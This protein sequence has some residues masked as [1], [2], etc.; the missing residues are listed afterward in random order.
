MIRRRSSGRGVKSDGEFFFNSAC[1]EKTVLLYIANIIESWLTERYPDIIFG[2]VS[3]FLGLRII[4][5]M[6]REEYPEAPLCESSDD[7]NIWIKHDA[8]KNYFGKIM[9]GKVLSEIENKLN[10]IISQ[11]DEELSIRLN[12]IKRA[13]SLNDEEVDILA[14]FYFVW[15]YQ[16]LANRLT[17]NGVIDFSN[18][19]TFKNMGHIILGHDK[20]K[21]LSNFSKRLLFT[22]SLL[23]KNHDCIEATTWA[24]N[25]LSGFLTTDISN[26]F[27]NTT[28]DTCLDLRDFDVSEEELLILN[29]L[30]EG[31][32]GCNIL[33]YGPPG[34]GK[35]SLAKV[36]AK[37]YSRELLSVNIP[38]DDDHSD[39][40]RSVYAAFNMADRNSSLILIDE[41]DEIL[42]TSASFFVNSKTNKSWINGMLETHGKRA[43]W[44]TNRTGQ[45]HPSTMRRF[46]FTMEFKKVTT[47]G[48][49]SILKHELKKKSLEYIFNDEELHDLCKAYPVDAGGIVNAIN[50]CEGQSKP[51]KDV[52]LKMIK[53]VLKNHERATM[54]EAPALSKK[55]DMRQYFLEGLNVS[56]D[57]DEIISIT[58]Q[59]VKLQEHKEHSLPLLLYGPPGTGKTEF[60]HYLGNILDKEVV[61]KR[62]SDIKS[63]WVGDT[64]ANIA[65]AFNEAQTEGGI[66]FFDEADSFLYPR[67]SADHSW[68]KSFTN[69]ILAQ[70]D[71]FFGIVI[72]A[73][74]DIDGLDHAALRRFR[75]KIEF[76]PL[77]PE[78]NVHFYQK[79]LTPLVS[80]GSAISE[81][82]TQQIRCM[83]NLTPG[84]FA[85]VKEQFVFVDAAAITHEKLIASLMNE[86]RHKQEKKR[87]IGFLRAIQ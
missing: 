63:K 55:K 34:T 12:N 86:A 78:G 25:Y 10:K 54:G 52:V 74:N 65:G 4:G 35:S 58:R 9:I 72:F 2:L 18:Y 75:F 6:I 40:L 5:D 48:R 13:F 15:L 85:V 64:E 8:S 3:D 1:E 32:K 27:F 44:I 82:D 83:S 47:K 57:L 76:H 49:L 70:L 41:A 24:E 16:P 56:H 7:F 51:Q 60:V 31:D 29:T 26:Q 42:N 43:V 28:N 33:F 37:Q 14:F 66:L 39:R 11:D 68:E 45:I 79:L 81:Q 61:L 30:M 87:G 59:Y 17:N 84:D 46:S 69:E 21:F 19:S 22:A 38:N 77:T 53:T 71:S 73:T 23:E 62:S 67:S 36:I 20:T 50:I 80:H